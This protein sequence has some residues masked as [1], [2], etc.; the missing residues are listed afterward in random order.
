M[1]RILFD[2]GQPSANPGGVVAVRDLELEHP[3]HE[4]RRPL[5]RPVRLRQV[6]TQLT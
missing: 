1:A 6:D 4:F 3:R 2:S 5:P